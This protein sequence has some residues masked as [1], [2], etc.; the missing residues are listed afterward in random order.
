ME[1]LVGFVGDEQRFDEVGVLG[2]DHALLALRCGVDV[3]VFGLVARRKIEGVDGVVPMP[4]SAEAGFFGS[5]ASTMNF[6][7][8]FCIRF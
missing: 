8:R 1:E 5:W 6:M 3:A 7:R 2:N 4:F